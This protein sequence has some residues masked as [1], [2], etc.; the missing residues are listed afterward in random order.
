MKKR[1]LALALAAA[2]AAGALMVPVSAKTTGVSRISE[3]A[4]RNIAVFSLASLEKPLNGDNAPAPDT[5]GRRFVLS[6]GRALYSADGTVG[7]YCFPFT[8]GI[9]GYV[10]ISLS[11]DLPYIMEQRFA[12]SPFESGN[13][14][15]T[16]YI[17]P[18]LY[19]NLLRDGTYVSQAG[20][21]VPAS[22]VKRTLKEYS[23]YRQTLAAQNPAFISGVAAENAQLLTAVTKIKSKAMLSSAGKPEFFQYLLDALFYYIGRVRH[24][25]DIAQINAYVEQLIMDNAGES[26]S[27]KE[28]V[29]VDKT[30]MVPRTQW[31]YEDDVGSGICGK[32][33]SMMALAFYRDGRGYANLPSD[34]EMYAEL[35]GIYDDMTDYFSFF[36]DNG[37][38][39]DLGLSESYEMVGTLDMGL[40]YYLYSKGYTQ[41]AQH[42]IDNANSAITMVPDVITGAL[43]TALKT[44]MSKWLAEMTG[45]ALSFSTPPTARAST[46]ITK[47]IRQGE[48]VVIGCLTAIGCDWFSNHY[49][50]GVGYYRLEKALSFGA[51][52]FKLTKEYIEVYDTWGSHSSVMDW[53]VF[54]STALYCSTSLADISAA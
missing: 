6:A 2:L 10:I 35:S 18:L 47:T 48:P 21:T 9:D 1:L 7:Y 13:I 45:G 31:Y 11:N 27:V 29:L 33:S 38:V 39:N 26:Y 41:A 23:V 52:E 8:G 50:A 51:S 12:P 25:V 30:Y 53:T 36:F 16:F 4:A 32:A 17:S 22:E 19:F 28:S 15:K 14:A 34:A 46:V 40:A 42:V 37:Q 3:A 44:A 20:I 43:M 49:F 24:N 54:K 5:R